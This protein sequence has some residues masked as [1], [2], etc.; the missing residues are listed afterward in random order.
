MSRGLGRF[1]P[2][3]KPG[4]IARCRHG[5]RFGDQCDSCRRSRGGWRPVK[6]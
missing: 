6:R 4:P 5:V 2:N 1:Y 3:P